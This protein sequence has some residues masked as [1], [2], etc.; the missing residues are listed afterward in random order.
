[1]GRQL[2]QRAIRRKRFVNGVVLGVVPDIAKQLDSQIK[3][4]TVH[5]IGPVGQIVDQLGDVS[6][7]LKF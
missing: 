3:L 4:V 2:A 6:Q 7:H 5:C 1:M